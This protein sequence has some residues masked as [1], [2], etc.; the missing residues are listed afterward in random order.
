MKKK[1]E[2]LFLGLICRSR[3]KR[4]MTVTPPPL[5]LQRK[6]PSRSP[7]AL[8]TSQIRV[9]ANKYE[10]ISRSFFG[11]K[12]VW[13]PKRRRFYSKTNMYVTTVWCAFSSLIWLPRIGIAWHAIS[14]LA[15]FQQVHRKGN[16]P[17]LK[18]AKTV[19]PQSQET[20]FP[21]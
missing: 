20:L 12:T 16:K 14:G 11:S 1:S 7:P 15:Q 9:P 17:G 10:H 13:E 6:T 4:T 8:W 21:F 2:N 3:E 19:A 18:D 5:W